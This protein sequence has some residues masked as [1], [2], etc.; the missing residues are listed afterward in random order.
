MASKLK[1]DTQFQGIETTQYFN[2]FYNT[3]QVHLLSQTRQ[4]SIHYHYINCTKEG[5]NIGCL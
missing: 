4:K 2:L 1:K 5:V 3:E